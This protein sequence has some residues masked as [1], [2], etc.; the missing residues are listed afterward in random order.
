M[1]TTPDSSSY[2]KSKKRRLSY[3]D[4]HRS[5]K[6]KY[7]FQHPK[8]SKYAEKFA[9][10]VR[11]VVEGD[12]PLLKFVGRA[13]I[14]LQQ[15]TANLVEVPNI[16]DNGGGVVRFF[17]PAYFKMLESV[18]LNGQSFPSNPIGHE[19]AVNLLDATVPL[20]VRSSAAKFHFRNHSQLTTTV[21]MIMGK[22]KTISNQPFKNAMEDLVGNNFVSNT[23]SLLTSPLFRLGDTPFHDEK[24]DIEVVTMKFDPGEKAE[25]VLR[26]P[27]MYRIGANKLQ[28]NKLISTTNGSDYKNAL[29]PG[30]GVNVMFRVWTEQSLAYGTTGSNNSNTGN[31]CSVISKGHGNDQ[32]TYIGA[33]A[34]DVRVSTTLET[35]EGRPILEKPYV[36]YVDY[37]LALPTA[38]LKW[39]DVDD[40][41]PQDKGQSDS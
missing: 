41:A 18:A 40:N 1:M 5:T 14:T 17:E 11:S 16:F 4:D 22:P 39:T 6:V 24:W 34:V 32:T 7:T 35:P 27:F 3:R 30:C 29:N 31:I 8:I 25:Y 26:G 36:G 12:K 9:K 19:T 23:G 15:K 28:D 21:Q 10:K 13:T 37:T 38:G 2:P 33:V 20:T